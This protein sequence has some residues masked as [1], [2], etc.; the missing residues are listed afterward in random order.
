MKIEIVKKGEDDEYTTRREKKNL[1][2]RLM[3]RRTMDSMAW[4][5]GWMNGRQTDEEEI[6]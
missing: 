6:E 2:S 5:D 3:N 4:M 1:A